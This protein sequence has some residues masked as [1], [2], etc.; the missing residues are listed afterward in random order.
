[1]KNQIKKPDTLKLLIDLAKSGQVYQSQAGKITGLSRQ[2][3]RWYS[4]SYGIKWKKYGEI[5]KSKKKSR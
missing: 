2:A 5:L 4:K 3:V 1:M